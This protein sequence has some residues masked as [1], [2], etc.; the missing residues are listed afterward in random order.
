M[1]TKVSATVTTFAGQLAPIGTILPYAGASAPTGWLMCDGS[2]ISRTT[3]ATLFGV[4]ADS[5]GVGDGSTTFNL[6][7]L[8]GRMPVGQDDM[9]GV[10]ASRMASGDEGIAA[11]T[12]AATGGKALVADA[13]KSHGLTINYIIRASSS[14]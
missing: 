2:A 6:P 4:A 10:S 13:G 8:R 3:Y 9:G 7:D 12:F 1:T 14:D 11:A 5:F